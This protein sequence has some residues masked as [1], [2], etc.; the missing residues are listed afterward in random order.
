[1]T[2]L[3][4]AILWGLFALIGPLVA[5]EEMESGG[6][7]KPIKTEIPSLIDIQRM[8]GAEPDGIYGPETERKWLEAYANQ[9]AAKFMTPSGGKEKP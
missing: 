7:N 5:L 1:M 8:V 9:E 6:K 2:K 4:K 3:I